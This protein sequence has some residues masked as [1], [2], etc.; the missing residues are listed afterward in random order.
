[1]ELLPLMDWPHARV[2]VDRVAIKLF[3]SL[4]D[5]SAEL[6]DAFDGTERFVL[7]ETSDVLL[8][9]LSLIATPLM[10]VAC[11]HDLVHACVDLISLMLGS[12]FGLFSEKSH[13]WQR[14]IARLMQLHSIGDIGQTAWIKCWDWLKIKYSS[15]LM[16]QLHTGLSSRV[17]VTTHQLFR[18]ISADYQ[19]LL[20]K[21]HSL[22]TR[23]SALCNRLH[24][25]IQGEHMGC[26]LIFSPQYYA[27]MCRYPVRLTDGTAGTTTRQIQKGDIWLVS[28]QSLHKN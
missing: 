20:L 6:K 9:I 13:S 11:L 18:W 24:S 12:H 8:Y 27:A 17:L 16:W 28:Q 21:R 4:S 23:R 22:T 3:G 5:S 26:K 7:S 19:S 14:S 10:Q 1:M 2:G 15:E 25:N